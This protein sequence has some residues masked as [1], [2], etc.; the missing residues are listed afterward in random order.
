M[1]ASFTIATPRYIIESELGDH[2][3]VFSKRANAIKNVIK[4]AAEYPG[5]VFHAVKKVNGKRTVIFSFGVKMQMDFQDLQ[6]VYRSIIEAYQKKLDKTRYW[7][8]SD[9]PGV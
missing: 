1:K 3:D 8:K 9:E 7:R 2:L 4:L 6:D 5:T